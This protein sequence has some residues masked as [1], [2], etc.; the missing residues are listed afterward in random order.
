MCAPARILLTVHGAVNRL[1]APQMLGSSGAQRWTQSARN[2]FS[3]LP[4]LCEVG[5]G[6]AAEA[7]QHGGRGGEP[8]EKRVWGGRLLRSQ[9][10]EAGTLMSVSGSGL[11]MAGSDGVRQWLGL[12][13][14]SARRYLEAITC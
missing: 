5:L 2:L 7:K 10:K 9:S 11:W 4:G 13:T 12:D 1:D 3:A 6:E 14:M 8:I